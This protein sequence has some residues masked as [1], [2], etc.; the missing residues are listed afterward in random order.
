MSNPALR[1][2]SSTW[3]HLGGLMEGSLIGGL[4]Q[5]YVGCP[6]HVVPVRDEIGIRGALLIHMCA[7]VV[8]HI[9][10]VR[11]RIIKECLGYQI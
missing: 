4:C 10:Q 2:C 8:I 3:A 6:E 11:L 5:E 1:G 7:V 9:V